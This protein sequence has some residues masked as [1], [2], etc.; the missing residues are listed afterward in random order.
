MRKPPKK[1]RRT[2]QGRASDPARI[3]P[4]AEQLSRPATTATDAL[5][6]TPEKLAIIAERVQRGQDTSHPGD[7]Q[8]DQGMAWERLME[9]REGWQRDGRLVTHGKDVFQR[10]EAGAIRTCA[11]PLEPGESDPP[12]TF[13]QRLRQVR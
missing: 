13:G 3:P 9:R 11:V 5:P 7:R 10:D 4:S 6:G 1:R 12:H 8:V 2:R